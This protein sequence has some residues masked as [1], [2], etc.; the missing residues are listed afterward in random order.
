MNNHFGTWHYTLGGTVA[1][2]LLNGS[3]L[4][5][6]ESAVGEQA[7]GIEKESIPRHH[8]CCKECVEVNTKRWVEM[9]GQRSPGAGTLSR[10]S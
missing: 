6:A 8:T 4:C 1:H 2:Y 5:G 10:T 3:F 9:S 7:F